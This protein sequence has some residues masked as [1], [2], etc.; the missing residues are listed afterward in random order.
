M[1]K[2]YKFQIFNLN[3]VTVLFQVMFKRYFVSIV[4]LFAFWMHCQNGTL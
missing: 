1:K 4:S 2:K 3:S